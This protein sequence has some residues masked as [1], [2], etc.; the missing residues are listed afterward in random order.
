M[1]SGSLAGT[2]AFWSFGTVA[3]AI[4][5]GAF[6]ERDISFLTQQL[7]LQPLFAAATIYFSFRLLP[8]DPAPDAEP[9]RGFTLPSP[10][11]LML[12]LVP[13]GAL[14]I[15]GAMME[16]SALLMREWKGA[17]PFVTALTFGV[18]ALAM[19]AIRLAG[20][21]LAELFGPRP[22]I[23]GSG[24]AMAIGIIGFGLAPGLWM[25]I[26]AAA[27]TGIGCGNIYP[28]T[29]SMVGQ[30]PGP[31]PERNVATLALIAFTA[32]L[33]AP[34]AIGTLA[35]H[36]GLPLAMALLAPLGLAP[37]LLLAGVGRRQPQ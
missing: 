17:G 26:P 25:S 23:Y 31:R 2:G 15:E 4:I 21:R 24:V 12:C 37:V 5:G 7:V 9:E 1:S 36:V 13:I 20:D 27:L 30:V 32:F 3:G 29:M 10:A 19:A 8:D 35:H 33:I 22:V 18:F 14:L 28:L 11:L 6:A 16:W 34:P